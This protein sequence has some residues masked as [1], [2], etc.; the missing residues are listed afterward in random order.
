MSEGTKPLLSPYRWVILIIMWSAVF[1]GIA[2]QFQV[3]ALAYK[4]IPDFKLTPGQYSM[5][6]TAP[7][8]AGVCFSFAAGALADRFGVKKW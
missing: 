5:I 7:M 8:L 2:A 1:I 3:A 6:L 4:I